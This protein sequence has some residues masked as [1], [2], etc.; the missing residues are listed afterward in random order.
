VKLVRF[1]DLEVCLCF[2]SY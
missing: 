2:F 1:K